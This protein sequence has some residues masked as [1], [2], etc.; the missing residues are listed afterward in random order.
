MRILL[1][2]LFLSIVNLAIGQDTCSLTFEGSNGYLLDKQTTQ[3]DN[4]ALERLAE[5]IEIFASVPKG[6]GV[7][8]KRI[9]TEFRLQSIYQ[10]LLK[11][12]YP[13]NIIKSSVELNDNAKNWNTIKLVFHLGIKKGDQVLKQTPIVQ[14]KKTYVA[15]T[16][17]TNIVIPRK[18]KTENVANAAEQNELLKVEKFK[19]NKKIRLPDL[20]FEPG[21]HFIIPSSN[22]VLTELVAVMQ[23]RPKLQIELQGHICCKLGGMDGF[24]PTTG[25]ENLSEMRAKVVYLYLISKGVSADRMKYRGFGSSRKLYPD[26]TGGGAAIRIAAAQN[27]RV[28]VLITATD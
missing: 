15:P 28:E 3:I 26:L 21:T 10:S 14:I 25:R 12:G 16:P 24:D 5:R 9:L 2:I 19:K 22:R 7:S 4:F 1:S 27:R 13:F 17:K 8:E 23:A 20:L 6:E 11:K 18:E